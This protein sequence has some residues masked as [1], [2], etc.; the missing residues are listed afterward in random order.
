MAP[1][2][3]HRGLAEREALLQDIFDASSVAIFLVDT[4]GRITHANQRMASMFGGTLDTLIGSHYVDHIHPM[5]R[6][7][8]RRKMLALL[9][10]SIPTIDVERAYRREDGSEFWGHLTGRRLHDSH[11]EGAR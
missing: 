6:D 4:S 10:S 7:D 5:E 1:T 2:P 8:G 11:G 3:G 9:A